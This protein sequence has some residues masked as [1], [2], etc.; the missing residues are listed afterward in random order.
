MVQ[1]SGGKVQ[2][3][4]TREDVNR[5]LKWAYAGAANAIAWH[6]E[7]NLGRH[8]SQLY[9]RL[10]QKKGHQKAVGAVSQHLSEAIGGSPS[11]GNPTGS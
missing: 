6:A 9:L 11:R 2:H 10:R 5:Y 3:G 7:K 8:V 1:Q 4:K